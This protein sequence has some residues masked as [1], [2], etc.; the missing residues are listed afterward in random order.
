MAVPRYI[1]LGYTTL[2]RETEAILHRE[3]GPGIDFLFLPAGVGGVAAA[4]TSYY[5]KK[6]ANRRPGLICVEP[7]D[8]DCF[9]ESV[10]YGKGLPLPT[11]GKQESIMAGLNCGIPSPVAWPVIRDGMDLFMAV[12]D[13]YARRAMRMYA[14]AGI[15]S[16]ESGASGLAGLLALLHTGKTADLRREMGFGHGSRVLLINTEG[17]TDPQSYRTIVHGE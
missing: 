16:G 11:R 10:R 5:V 13:D 6:Y 7:L 9:L 4:G 12:S 15:V 1:M 3:G 2:F 8:C 14:G 17:D